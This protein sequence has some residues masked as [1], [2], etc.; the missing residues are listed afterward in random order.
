MKR[1]ADV[2]PKPPYAETESDDP[3]RLEDPMVWFNHEEPTCLTSK[4]DYNAQKSIEAAQTGFGP[5]KSFIF[6]I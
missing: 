4:E 5:S 1:Y 2:D 6:Q 3:R